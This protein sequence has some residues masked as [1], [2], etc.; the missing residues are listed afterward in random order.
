MSCLG[1]EISEADY[2]VDGG[3][4]W[5]PPRHLHV[6]A[7]DVAGA[8]QSDPQFVRTGDQGTSMPL[9]AMRQRGARQAGLA[10]MPG[11]PVHFG[12]GKRIHA[13]SNRGRPGRRRA[14]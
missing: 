9:K 7:V 1:V 8:R 13:R 3:G 10:S 11:R 12:G 5:R 2:T 6:R 4:R 14:C